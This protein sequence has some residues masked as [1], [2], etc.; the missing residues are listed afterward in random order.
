M[1]APMQVRIEVESLSRSMRFAT[2]ATKIEIANAGGKPL[3]DIALDADLTT[4][5]GSIAIHDQLAGAE[6]QLEPLDHIEMLEEGG[7]V[8]LKKQVRLPLLQVRPIRQGRAVLYVPLLRLR[9]SSE[10]IDPI[11]RTFVIGMRPAIPGDKLQPFRLDE[12][13]QTYRMIGAR[14]LD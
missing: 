9:V 3:S 8:S 11:L 7:T 14:I 5:H 1:Q 12:T 4:A 13:P 6:T 2:L 10:G